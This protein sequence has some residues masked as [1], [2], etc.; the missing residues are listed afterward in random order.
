MPGQAAYIII[1]AISDSKYKQCHITLVLIVKF[2]TYMR[3]FAWLDRHYPLRYIGSKFIAR[4][5]IKLPNQ[6]I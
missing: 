5:D 2:A 6:N 4:E 3:E 1:A